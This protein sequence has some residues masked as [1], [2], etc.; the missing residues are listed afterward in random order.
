[1]N[2]NIDARSFYSKH[3]PDNQNGLSS[4]NAVSIGGTVTGTSAKSSQTVKLERVSLFDQ[5]KAGSKKKMSPEIIARKIA[6]GKSVTKEEM[7]YLKEKSPD[8]YRK[9]VNA[10]RIRENLERALKSAKSDTEKANAIA[11]ASAEASVLASADTSGQSGGEVSTGA[12]LYTDA[13]QAAIQNSSSKNL[14][15]KMEEYIKSSEIG[16]SY[17]DLELNSF[18]EIV[19]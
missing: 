15:K 17:D 9:A 6:C 8:M 7:Q 1:M 18:D 16:Q 5:M 12:G 14:N 3:N 13:I 4:T 10:N 2:I 19:K 11:A